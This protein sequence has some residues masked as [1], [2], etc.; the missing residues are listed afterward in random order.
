MILVISTTFELLGTVLVAITIVHILVARLRIQSLRRA[1]GGRADKL[2]EIVE[3]VEYKQAILPET[4]EIGVILFGVSLNIFGL[5]LRLITEIYHVS[6]GQG[7]MYLGSLT[8]TAL[9]AHYL[10]A[11]QFPCSGLFLIG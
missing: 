7:I 8:M 11:T 9:C 5:A 6:V 2:L 1:S 4:W 10:A 3:E